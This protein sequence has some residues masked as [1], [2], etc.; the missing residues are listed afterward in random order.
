MGSGQLCI[1]LHLSLLMLLGCCLI[2]VAGLKGVFRNDGGLGTDE[3]HFLV[4][5]CGPVLHGSPCFHDVDF[6]ALAGNPVDYAIQF[7]WVDGVGLYRKGC[8]IRLQ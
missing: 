3:W 5:F 4:E 1:H 2:Y 7:S 8:T 6:A